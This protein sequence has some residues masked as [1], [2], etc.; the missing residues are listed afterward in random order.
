MNELIQCQ[1]LNDQ[2]MKKQTMNT[3]KAHMEQ[4]LTEILRQTGDGTG[5]RWTG[6]QTDLVEMLYTVYLDGIFIDDKGC[7]ETFASLVRRVC[8]TLHVNGP[9]NPR[10]VAYI[11]RSRKGFHQRPFLE[12]YS[13]MLYRNHVVEPLHTLI[14]KK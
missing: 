10:A 7:P 11:A 12:R 4:A 6:T 3:A 2:A 5:M 8:R 9:K 14:T 1:D 13:A